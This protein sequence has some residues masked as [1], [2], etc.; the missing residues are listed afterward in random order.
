M[1]DVSESRFAADLL[2]AW[3]FDVVVTDVA[4]PLIDGV[5]VLRAVRERDP[6][7]PVVLMSGTANL[8]SALKAVEHGAL[9]Y[10]EKPVDVDSLR[11]IVEDAVRLR[12]IAAMKRRAL[13]Q[14][15]DTSGQESRRAELLARFEHA[16]DTV[17][18]LFQPIVRWSDRTVFGYEALV[19]TD[20]QTLGHPGE[21]YAA[22]AALDELH[23]AG[24]VIRRAV[25]QT[26][27]QFA[28][29]E[30]IFVNV[31]PRDLD[32]DELT[33]RTSPLAAFAS[34]VVLEV[35]EWAALEP[36]RDLPGRLSALRDVGYRFALDD[37]GSGYSGLTSFAQ[38][39]PEVVKLDMSLTRGVA[40]E[41]TKR[42]LIRSMTT[43]C[44]ELGVLVIAEGVETPEERDVLVGLGCDLLQGFLFARPGLP[45]QRMTWNPGEAAVDAERPPT[46]PRGRERVAMPLPF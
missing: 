12:R 19:R 6:D 38:L 4:M 31:H 27:R 20:E 45:L 44:E 14:Y 41:P 35:T 32:D 33:S 23:R 8:A 40:A 5:E 28:G 29:S 24:R 3:E 11:Q 18:M 17:H 13:E 9:R 46:L 26:I 10:L 42:K 25:S 7:I 36:T 21:L 37:L 15:H 1:V 16:L 22:A 30:P 2:G 39:R 43:L 34:R